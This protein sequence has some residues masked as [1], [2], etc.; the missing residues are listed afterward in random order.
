MKDSAFNDAIR[1]YYGPK[2]RCRLSCLFA[3]TESNGGRYLGMNIKLIRRRV[4]YWYR[5]L[6]KESDEAIEYMW[7]A[8][9]NDIS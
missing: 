3:L 8:I 5:I 9:E 1:K 7:K 4:I 6:S 2:I